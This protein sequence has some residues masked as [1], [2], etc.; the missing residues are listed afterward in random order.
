MLGRFFAVVV[1]A[2]ACAL[3]M[4][5]SR[6]KVGQLGQTIE[7]V[8]IQSKAGAGRTYYSCKAYEY[9]VLSATSNGYYKVLLQNGRYGYVASKS[10]A[11]LPYDVTRPK[12]TVDATTN[13]SS[14]DRGVSLTSRAA[15]ARE[16]LKYQ[17]RTYYKWGGTD[18][19]GGIDCSA[20]VK[21]LYGKIGL[22]LPRTAAEQAKV[23][24]PIT[25]LEDL[26][27]GD[28]LY[29]WSS[30][31]GQIGHTGMYLGNGYFVHSSSNHN[32]VAT[33]YLGSQ[34]WLNILV[35]ARR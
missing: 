33:D 2:M 16:G 12:A 15:A 20:F 25:R 23:G 13:Y 28:R 29:F 19:N 24:T 8:K 7:P 31:R 18:P 9:L 14:F 3:S 22:N 11:A 4:A 1:V 21:M 6:V 5:D 17:G 32:G 30:K 27:A 10:V 35:A 34:K 26:K